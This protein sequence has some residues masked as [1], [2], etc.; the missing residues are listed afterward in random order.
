M[1]CAGTSGLE[2]IVV[3]AQKREQNINDVDVAVSAFSG[4][5]MDAFGIESS[6]DLMSLKY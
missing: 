3:T 5:Q 6:T 4:E 1:M 2:E